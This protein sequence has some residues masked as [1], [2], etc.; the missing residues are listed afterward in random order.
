M[1]RLRADPQALK[2]YRD[3]QRAGRDLEKVRAASKRGHA[4]RK[5]RITADPQFRSRRLETTRRTAQR[6]QERM[7]ID[8]AYREHRNAVMRAWYTKNRT[9]QRVKKRAYEA[10]R[11]EELNARE[12]QKYAQDRERRRE[13]W[14]AW[15][16][17]NPERVEAYQRAS[18]HRRRNAPGSF[19]GAEWREVL[20]QHG[21]CCYYCGAW[22]I[23]LWVDHR[24]PFAR[25]GWNVPL[26]IVPACPPCNLSKG[27]LTDVEFFARLATEPRQL[28]DPRERVAIW[29]AGFDAVEMVPL[30][31]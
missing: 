3:K 1:A 18:D 4:R 13:Y 16:A 8:P 22:G 7:R 17:R 28:P 24:I 29:V 2:A 30:V 23:D 26:N 14:K 20:H 12:R 9:E 19:T 31:V 5:Q 15:M 21:Y 10:G 25:G 11:R 27:T 6:R